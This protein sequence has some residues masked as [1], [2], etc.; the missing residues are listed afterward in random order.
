[1]VATVGQ[2]T[3]ERRMAAKVK[4][5]GS[6]FGPD[7]VKGL[8]DQTA[9]YTVINS[10]TAVL[11]FQGGFDPST[12]YTQTLTGYGFGI[13][14]DGRYTGTV[15]SFVGVNAGAPKNYWTF[16]NLSSP[17]ELMN[18]NASGGLTFPELLVSPL[19]Y[20]FIGD[21]FDDVF[22]LSSDAD[23]AKGKG[24]D[25]T[26][27]ALDGS[28]KLYGGGGNDVLRGDQGDDQLDGGKGD[29]EIFGGIGNDLIFGRSGND[30]IYAGT[31]NDTVH[32]EDGDDVILGEDG[33]DTLYGGRGR[34]KI[35]GGA[36]ADVIH[37]GKG[38]DQ[39][40]GGLDEDTLR[41]GAGD[42]V[43]NAGP[44]DD[45]A[46]NVMYGGNG[47]D[48]IYGQK[49]AD[50]LKGGKGADQLYGGDNL[51]TLDGGNGKDVLAGGEGSDKLIG[52]KGN[53]ILS[54]NQS[55]AVVYDNGFDTFI[56]FGKFGN[57]TVTDFHIGFDLIAFAGGITAADV[58]V[59]TKGD[60]V[61]IIVKQIDKQSV[62]VKGVADQ[63][64][65]DI[66]IIYA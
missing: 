22:I 41:G 63:F 44:V 48:V 7:F 52:G 56:F 3:G 15:T 16:T 5:T 46:G 2:H 8:A 19:S 33:T 6:F 62:L 28:D 21:R 30:M 49:G 29:D 25:D 18:T 53:D 27:T 64:D 32:G 55:D 37:G 39:L 57:D 10:T 26:F 45:E 35:D 23:I 31:D 11:T 58:T 40:D 12:T 59:K 43:L 20:K 61:K 50:T 9:S 13:T 38:K 17:L 51:D 1:M 42:D 36:G 47:D 34:D 65:P 60:D 14:E 4:I 54:G 24:G 66:D